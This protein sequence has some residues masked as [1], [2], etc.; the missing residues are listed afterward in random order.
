MAV[1]A[2]H[3]RDLVAHPLG[4]EHLLHPEIIQPRLMAV[5]QA[6]RR[7]APPYRK[8]RGGRRF[9]G[10]LPSTRAHRVGDLVPHKH[11]IEP[12]QTRP[13]AG[14]APA[15]LAIGGYPPHSPA[16]WRHELLT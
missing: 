11:S 3:A 10:L 8:P 15:M 2:R 6:M 16:T 1:H 4:L 7:Q 13:P 9:T 14:R 5:P 12:Q